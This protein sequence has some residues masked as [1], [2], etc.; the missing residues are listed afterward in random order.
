MRGLKQPIFAEAREANEPH[1][2]IITERFSSVSR[3]LQGLNAYRYA[4]Q[5]SGGNQEW[6]ESASFQHYL[7]T[8]ELISYHDA[9]AKLKAISR[10]SRPKADSVAMDVEE[11]IQGVDEGVGRCLTPEDYLLGIYDMTGELMRFAITTM[12]TNGALPT[13]PGT[14]RNVLTDMRELRSALESLD[15]GFGPFASDVD[16]KMGVMKA[17]VEKVERAL[18]DLK[19]RGAERPKGWVPDS[20]AAPR[21]VEVES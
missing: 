7:E 4:R 9:A 18:Y 2:K 5:I 12:A 20:D 3:D 16:K 10:P 8:A 13:I 6:M 19:V 1:H 15:V 17:S 11:S 21:P 14:N